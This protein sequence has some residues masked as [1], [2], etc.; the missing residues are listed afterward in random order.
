MIELIICIW[1]DL[2]GSKK[3][4]LKRKFGILSGER[5]D[6]TPTDRHKP[7][8]GEENELEHERIG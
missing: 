4:F 2:W 7:I 6:K 3:R 8:L 1:I 5:E